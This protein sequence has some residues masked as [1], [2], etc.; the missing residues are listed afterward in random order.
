MTSENK[1]KSVVDATVVVES[2]H[3]NGQGV[4]IK[5]NLILT[6]AHCVSYSAEGYMALSEYYIERIKTKKGSELKVRPLAVEPVSDVA[7]LGT[8]DSQ[9]FPADATKF[10]DFCE[11]IEPVNLGMGEPV[12]WEEFTVYAYSHKGYWITGKATYYRNK[13]Y[14]ININTKE[15]ILGGTSGGPIVNENGELVA[16]ASNAS[17]ITDA[18]RGSHGT[19]PLLC[20]ALPVWV[21]N[22]QSA[23]TGPVW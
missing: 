11:E 7:V 4:L 10:E 15:Q 2:K 22:L 8:P 5:N 3:G 21:I 18:E 20:H 14:L 9:G 12:P 13:P 16:I 17:I 1:F 6:A 23:E 19:H